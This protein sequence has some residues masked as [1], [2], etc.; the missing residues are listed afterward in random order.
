MSKNIVT[1]KWFERAP[2]LRSGAV[3]ISPDAEF[4]DSRNVGAPYDN[5]KI[6]VVK[7]FGKTIIFWAELIYIL[8]EGQPMPEDAEEV[9]TGKADFKPDGSLHGVFWRNVK[10]STSSRF[11]ANRYY[12][13]DPIVTLEDYTFA[14][15][16]AIDFLISYN[17]FTSR[18]TGPV[19]KIRFAAKPRSNVSPFEVP[20][21]FD[22]T[23]ELV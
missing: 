12:K 18:S 9:V 17:G 7:V 15:E 1:G 13:A 8:K 10:F 22:R 23:V 14:R 5:T 3:S 20:E 11:G 21:N 19:H 6:F 2:N 16:V 4:V